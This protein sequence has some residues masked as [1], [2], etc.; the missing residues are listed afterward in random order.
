LGVKEAGED[1]GR[2]IPFAGFFLELLAAGAGQL[3]ELGFAVVFRYA[4]FRGDVAV[5]LEFKEGRVERTVVDREQISAGL[6]NAAGDA[7]AVEQ[8]HGLKSL[9]DHQRESAL[10]DVLLVAYDGF[11]GLWERVLRAPMAYT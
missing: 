11:S 5:L 9:E 7:V 1:G 6:L 3:V 4:P 2:L 8:A 10:P